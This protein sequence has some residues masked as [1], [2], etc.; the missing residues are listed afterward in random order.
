[1]VAGGQDLWAL[2]KTL[3]ALTAALTVGSGIQYLLVAPRYV[4]WQ[5]R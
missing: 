3:L 4:D 2:R 5:G 1:V